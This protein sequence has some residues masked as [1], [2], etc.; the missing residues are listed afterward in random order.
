MNWDEKKPTFKGSILLKKANG[1][2]IT[3]AFKGDYI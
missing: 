3:V 2:I 1:E